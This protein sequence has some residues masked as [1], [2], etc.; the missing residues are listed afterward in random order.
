V[1]CTFLAQVLA[2]LL[3]HVAEQ[4]VDGAHGD[5]LDGVQHEEHEWPPGESLFEQ[6][7]QLGDDGLQGFLVPGVASG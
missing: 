7:E 2:E 1:R 6:V 4:G 3:V 5:G